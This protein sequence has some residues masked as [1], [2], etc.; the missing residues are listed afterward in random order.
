MPR[1]PVNTSVLVLVFFCCVAIQFRQVFQRWGTDILSW[2]IGTYLEWKHPILSTDGQQRIPTCPYRFPNGQGDIAKFLEGEKNSK[3]WGKVHGKLYR[4]WS[5]TNQEIVLSNPEDIKIVFRDSDVHAKAKNNDAGW[6][7]SE[8]LGRCVGLITG[9]EWRKVRAVTG[10]TFTH[11][12]AAASVSAVWEFTKEHFAKLQEDGKLSS[13][14]IN[15]V[16]DFRF[17]PFWIVASHLYGPLSPSLKA[18]LRALVPLRESLF[19][20]VI[21]G[22]ATRF[23]GSQLL[24]TKANR[25]L[26]EFKRRWWRFNK[27][28]VQGCLRD[29]RNAPVVEMYE[30][31]RGGRMD[32]EN[33]HQTLDEMLFA[34]LD[35]T[36]GAISWNLL[37]LAANPDIQEELRIEVQGARIQG[38][39]GKPSKSADEYLLS[40]TSLLTACTL[41]S[42]RLKPAA[43]FTVPQAASTDRVVSDMVIPAGINFIVDTHALNIRNQYWGPDN[44]LYRPARFVG[45]K[46]SEMRYQYWRFGFGPRQCMGKHM[47]DLVIRVL[48][49][50]L[51]ERFSLSLG[52]SSSWDKNPKAWISH[53]ETQIL[54]EPL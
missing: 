1:T 31:M 36:I 3:A 14:Q 24:P 49:V 35:V 51:V 28:A 16:E 43:A 7:M 12:N 13:G 10:S 34:N 11:K 19:R 9:E 29:K 40:S 6:L 45:R 48:L 33:L 15:P 18:E 5:G 25:E 22:G 4:L 30:E 47:A 46:P 20:S 42:A 52:P 39:P 54:C 2:V 32:P 23:S 27:E 50:Y 53:T 8:L 17:L 38:E 21:Q 44:E 37:F 26:R 41:E